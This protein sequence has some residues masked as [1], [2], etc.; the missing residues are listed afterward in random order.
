MGIQYMIKQ[1]FKIIFFP[2]AI[3]KVFTDHFSHIK[4]SFELK[5]KFCG[6]SLDQFITFIKLSKYLLLV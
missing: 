2:N 3:I 4:A 1:H 5:L 6:I